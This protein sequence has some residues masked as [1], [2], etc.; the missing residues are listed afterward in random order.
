MPQV[1]G[2]ELLVPDFPGL[3]FQVVAK[4]VERMC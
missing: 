2:G 1:V 3:Q 4:E